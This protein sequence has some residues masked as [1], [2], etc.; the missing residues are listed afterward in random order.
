MADFI[1]NATTDSG[2]VN[3]PKFD[4]IQLPPGTDISHVVSGSEWNS[5][6]QAI[7]DTR[8]NML[9]G[10]FFGFGQRFA[11]AA[12]ITPPAA[13]SEGRGPGGAGAGTVAAINS[14]DFLYVRTDGSLIQ[15]KKDGSEFVLAAAAANVQ[16]TQYA[17]LD[18][19][20]TP[21][22]LPALTQGSAILYLRS[23]GSTTPGSRRSQLVIRWGT[24]NTDTV[25]AEGP[26]Y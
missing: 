18:T 13:D 3:L 10:S 7:L 19:L 16:Y 15:H 20:P 26:I 14:L 8:R 25:I 6:C 22:I 17:E 21:V 12:S 23:N 1:V 24:N 9:S 4:Q 11:G 2:S 5:V